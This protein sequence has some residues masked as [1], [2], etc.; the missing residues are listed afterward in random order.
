ME[1]IYDFLGNVGKM[2]CYAVAGLAGALIVSD[3]SNADLIRLTNVSANYAQNDVGSDTSVVENINHPLITSGYDPGI[4][5]LE[6]TTTGLNPLDKFFILGQ[7][8]D[9]NFVNTNYTP[10]PK[11]GTQYEFILSAVDRDFTGFNADNYVEF[12]T[13]DINNPNGVTGYTYDLAVDT[14]LNGSFDY[15]ESG[16]V[17]EGNT[18]GTW[19]QT[20]LPGGTNYGTLTLTATPEPSAITLGALG[21]AGIPLVLGSRRRR[22]NGLESKVE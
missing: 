20:M 19:N 7:D 9:G 6:S 18:T 5:T 8:I 21:V 14:D 16:N 1:K 22:N 2:G 11:I 13:V 10:F 3:K 17:V 15:L 12:T 4:D